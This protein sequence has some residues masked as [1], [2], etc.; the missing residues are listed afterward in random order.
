MVEGEARAAA[1][2]VTGAVLM[3]GEGAV[4]KEVLVRVFQRR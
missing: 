1:A 2:V 3:T 4:I